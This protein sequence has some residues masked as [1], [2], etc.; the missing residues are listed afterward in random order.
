MLAAALASLAGCCRAGMTTA[1]HPECICS[2]GTLSTCPLDSLSRA[3]LKLR[4]DGCTR[5]V[6]H[7][8]RS[9]RF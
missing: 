1:S 8:G 3:I 4:E 2:P 6:L 5:R 7:C 9:R